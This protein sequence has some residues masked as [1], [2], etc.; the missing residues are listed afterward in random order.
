MDAKGPNGDG[1]L[2]LGLS[3]HKHACIVYSNNE[4]SDGTVLLRKLVRVLAAHL[5]KSS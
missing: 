5:F 4:C 1:C 2:I 3:I